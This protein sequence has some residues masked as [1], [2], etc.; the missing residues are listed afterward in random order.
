MPYL[1]QIAAHTN[2]QMIERYLQKDGRALARDFFNLSIDERDGYGDEGKDQIEWADEMDATRRLAGNDAPFGRLAARTYKHFVL[3]P[4]PEDEI[5]LESL[6][7]LTCAW[8]LKH[9]DGYQI[10]I[11]Y[12][13]DNEGRIPHAHI[14][15]NNTNL[16]TGRRMH[17]DDPKEFNRSLQE[18]AKERGLLHLSN[19]EE[20]T[21]GIARLAEK[22]KSR[23]EKPKTMQQVHLGRAEKELVD[24]GAYSWVAD[25]RNRV[26]VAKSLAR[27]EGEFMKIL[28]SLEV[29]VADNSA[30]AKRDDWV[31][32]LADEPTKKVTGERLGLLYAK[33]TIRRDF[34]RAGSYHPDAKS[35]KEILMNAK[36][37]I[38]I[39]DIASLNELSRALFVCAR[40]GV[41]SISDCDR[42][43]SRLNTMAAN[44]EPKKGRRLLESAREL[45]DARNYM[46]ANNLLPEK[47]PAKQSPKA[48][49]SNS[50]QKQE[51]RAIEQRRRA[52]QPEESRE[53]RSR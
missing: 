48:T 2:C 49:K 31:F 35:S 50:S 15:V 10:A 38:L 8:A 11:V 43:I 51:K 41:S 19:E 42:R 47:S 32:S 9:F 6:R 53:E 13:D 45:E 27:N 18:M 24:S 34:K 25:I 21:E 30:K 52:Q 1:K 4:S 29:N 36:D 39:N 3:S 5:D 40:N 12:H 37:A 20:H 28:E 33:E 17:H 16:A 26:S 46:A 7:E 22:G 14:V 44:A 23:K